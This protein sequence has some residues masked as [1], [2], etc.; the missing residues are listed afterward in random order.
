M[1]MPNI[2][3]PGFPA[4]KA[5]PS[6]DARLADISSALSFNRFA[7]AN[8]TGSPSLREYLL[9]LDATLDHEWRTLFN[10]RPA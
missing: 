4:V 3:M 5:P 10:A 9:A 6:R 1:I 7:L 2:G 8:E